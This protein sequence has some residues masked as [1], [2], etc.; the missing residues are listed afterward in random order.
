MQVL[1]ILNSVLGRR[2]NI[3]YTNMLVVVVYFLIS[4]DV[5]F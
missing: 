4:K 5:P 2:R 1:A 3:A